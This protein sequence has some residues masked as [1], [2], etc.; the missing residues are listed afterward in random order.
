M[1]KI[2]TLLLLFFVFNSAFAQF[3]HQNVNLLGTFDDPSVQPES[4]YGI[5]YQGCWGYADS[6]GNEYGI[7]GS[8][9]GTYFVDITDPT[10]PVQKTYIPHRQNDC[11][12]HEYKSYENYL[13]I[14]SD[15][16]GS[17]TNSL[18]IVDMKYLPDSIHMVYDDTTIF[19]HSHTQYID[20]NRWYVAL[21]LIHN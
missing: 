2:L 14:I 10:N 13:Y 21:S 4:V 16:G 5:R 17:P 1:R 15:D 6:L 20:G 18:Q 8:T 7:I 19:V 3:A 9:A 11:I 12:W